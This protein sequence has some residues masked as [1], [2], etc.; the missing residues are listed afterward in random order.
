[1]PLWNLWG[2]LTRAWSLAIAL[3]HMLP[4]MYRASPSKK[5]CFKPSLKYAR[6]VRSEMPAG[7]KLG[8]AGFCWGGYQ[9]VN[10]CSETT[11]PGGSER[12]VDAQFC[13]HPSRLKLPDDVVDA[14]VKFKTPVSIAHA[15]KDY[16]LPNKQM[17][18]TEATL[19]QKAGNG[20]GEEGYWWSIRYYEDAPHGFAVRAREGFKKEEVAADE[21]KEQAI[22]WFKRWL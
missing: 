11:V 21:A 17:Q 3:S 8:V 7:T 9:S 5:E 6:A 4:F 19:R 10:L 22:E 2:Q 15:T 13:A 20:E 16:A 1:V 14:V 18:E 12:L